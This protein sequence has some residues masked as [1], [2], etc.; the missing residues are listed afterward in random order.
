MKCD[1]RL[2]RDSR[3]EQIICSYLCFNSYMWYDVTNGIP[4]ICTPANRINR[5]RYSMGKWKQYATVLCLIALGSCSTADPRFTAGL[6]SFQKSDFAGAHKMWLP[7]ANAGARNAQHGLGWLYEKGLGV[8]QNYQISAMWYRKAADQGHGGAQLNLGNFYDNGTGFAKDYKKAAA[9][10]A[11]SAENNIAE[12]QNNLGQ[13]Y[14]LGQGI[15]QDFEI[16]AT[17][18]LAAARQN[19]APAQNAIGLMYFKGQGIEQDV[20]QAYFWVTLAALNGQAGSEH[21][22]SF[23]ATFLEQIQIKEID[24]LASDWLQARS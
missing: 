21:N 18:L 22:S 10:F 4:A 12:A 20:E 6:S 24:G 16:A 2:F 8:A 3:E 5:R 17:L 9:Y 7:A 1:C 13:M 14:K 11:K 23:I 15:E 19:Y